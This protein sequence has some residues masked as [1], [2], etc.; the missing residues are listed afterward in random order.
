MPIAW[1]PNDAERW[2]R[3]CFFCFYYC[4][5]LCICFLLF[6]FLGL[7]CLFFWF[8][9]IINCRNIVSEGNIAFLERC[10][11]FWRDTASKNKYTQYKRTTIQLVI[12]RTWKKGT[13]NIASSERHCW[14]RKQNYIY[15]ILLFQTPV[16]KHFRMGSC[17]R[18]FFKRNMVFLGAAS[19]AG[20]QLPSQ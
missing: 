3:N 6:T 10:F 11:A 19:G 1:L 7:C 16:E 8:L 17:E 20:P 5:F 4:F 2:V 13:W 12:K 15:Y 9:V 18:S 14:F